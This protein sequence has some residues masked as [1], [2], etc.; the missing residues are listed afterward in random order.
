MCDGDA[1][2]TCEQTARST[3]DGGGPYLL[4]RSEAASPAL[5]A[6]WLLSRALDLGVQLDGVGLCA[7]R[8]ELR[9]ADEYLRALAVLGSG[10]AYVLELAVDDT[11]HRFTA[12]PAARHGR[13]EPAAGRTW[14][15]G[16]T[17]GHGAGCDA[18]RDAG[19]AGVPARPR[20]HAAAVP[21]GS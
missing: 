14:D 9:D 17:R 21:T 13:A 8:G 20:T 16:L 1:R 19:R 6:Y 10:F 4:A 18:G 12:R 15:A 7:V 2:F 3:R 11:V 5:A